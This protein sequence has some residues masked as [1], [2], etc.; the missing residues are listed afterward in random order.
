MSPYDRMGLKENFTADEW[1]N[2]LDLPYAV[3]M[4]IIAA[5][6]NVMGIWGETKTMMTAPPDLAASSGSTLAGLIS[7]ETQPKLKD[8][9][10]EQQNLWKQDMAGYRTRVIAFC[11]SAAAAL[12]KVPAKEANAYKKW[13]LA[14][15]L[16]VAEASKEHGVAVSD[17]EKAALA[18]ISAALG[19]SG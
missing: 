19:V 16:K 5:A 9:V 8:L 2:L 18:E 14:I 6:P 3:S 10:K 4:A 7:A 15:G 1:K 12:A 17:P 11:T 13:V